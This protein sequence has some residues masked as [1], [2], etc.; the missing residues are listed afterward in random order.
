MVAP[1]A[2]CSK[3][4]STAEPTPMMTSTE[5]STKCRPWWVSRF[6][7]RLSALL[8]MRAARA[9]VITRSSLSRRSA[10]SGR[11]TGIAMISRSMRWRRTNDQRDGERYSLTRYSTAKTAQ[12]A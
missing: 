6:R 11:S 7:A 12:T 8:R 5:S 2:C 9:R 10:R 4:S 3:A 1:G